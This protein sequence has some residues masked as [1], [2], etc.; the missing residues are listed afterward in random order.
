MAAV[1]RRCE[2]C[3]RRRRRHARRT[4]V[5]ALEQRVL[6]QEAL[7]LLVELDRRQLQQPDRLLQLRRQR[8]VLGEP[9]LEGVLHR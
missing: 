6:L 4:A 8:E 1:C 3:Y 7:D 9:E 2:P 5:L